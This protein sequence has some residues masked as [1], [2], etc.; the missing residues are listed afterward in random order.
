SANSVPQAPSNLTATAASTSQINLTW[1]D[2]ASNESGFRVEQSLD[3]TT[4][5]PAGTASADSTSFSVTGLSAGTTYYFRVLA[6]NGAGDSTWS[7]TAQATTQ[8][9]SQTLTADRFEVNNTV[10]TATK[11]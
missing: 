3:G 7:N 10:A 2:N 8:A 9:V 4:F 1:Q 5:T 6:F 11:L